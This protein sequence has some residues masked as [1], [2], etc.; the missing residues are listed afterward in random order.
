V[1]NQLAYSISS[2]NIFS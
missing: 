2:L 1:N